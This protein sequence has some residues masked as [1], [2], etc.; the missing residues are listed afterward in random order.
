MQIKRLTIWAV[1]GTDII[2]IKY[3]CCQVLIDWSVGPADPLKIC[4]FCCEHAYIAKDVIN[5]KGAVNN[6]AYQT[7]GI[8]IYDLKLETN[9]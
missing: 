9:Q 8:V 6:G 5:S 7:L 4:F 3:V 2:H 1:T